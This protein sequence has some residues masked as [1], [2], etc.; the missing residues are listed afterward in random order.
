MTRADHGLARLSRRAFLALVASAGAGRVVGATQDHFPFGPL[1]VPRAVP[2]WRVTRHDGTVHALTDLVRGRV[3]ALQVM[4]TSCRA[5]CPLQ[6]AIFANVQRQLG[7]A[8]P[9]AQL[10]SLTI[11]P[12]TDTPAVMAD[13]LASTGA[14]PAWAGITPAP[15]D[16][17]AIQ[18][19]LGD[20]GLPR[21]QGADPHS[22]Q[23][24]VID[25][26]G[27]LVFRTA[28]MPAARKVV[29]ALMYA[30]SPGR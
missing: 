2:G 6:A 29:D 21:P 10:L 11:D 12:A 9:G 24:Y 13:W 23:V 4:F 1:S 18:A 27:R 22:G 7:D 3:T 28:A 25:R 30:D 5:T 16:V 26:Q 17:T 19:L 20:G 8:V 15:S 14:G